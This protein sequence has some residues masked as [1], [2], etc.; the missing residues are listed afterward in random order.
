MEGWM[1]L[2][3][4]ILWGGRMLRLLRVGLNRAILGSNGGKINHLIQG[5]SKRPIRP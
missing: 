4:R 1:I 5:I 2:C 3:V